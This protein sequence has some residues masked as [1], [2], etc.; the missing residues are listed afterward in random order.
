VVLAW[1][2]SQPSTGLPLKTIRKYVCQRSNPAAVISHLVTM[3]GRISYRSVPLRNLVIVIS[4]LYVILSIV[5]LFQPS[6]LLVVVESGSRKTNDDFLSITNIDALA[7]LPQPTR[8][9]PKTIILHAPGALQRMM[10][11][12][13]QQSQVVRRSELQELPPN[14]HKKLAPGGS[15]A[16]GESPRRDFRL[17]DPNLDKIFFLVHI[18]K[19]AGSSMCQMA[20][21]N[22]L[23][24]ERYSN[25]NVQYDLRCCG[26]QDSVEAQ[27]QF[28]KTSTYDFVAIEKEMYHSMAPEYY[29]YI[30]ILRNSRLRYYSH[31]NHIVKEFQGGSAV[32][33][34]MASTATALRGNDSKDGGTEPGTRPRRGP[35]TFTTWWA[36]QPDNWNTRMICGPKCLEH[37]KY[38]I[39]RP[40][41][42]ET[43]SRLALFEDILFVESL[44]ESYSNFTLK[45][46]W[47]T[48]M[49]MDKINVKQNMQKN[50]TKAS[51]KR[52]DPL[53]S[54]LDDALYEFG[55][56]K[57]AGRLPPNSDQQWGQFP[58]STPIQQQL[59]AYFAMG[60]LQNCTSICC[61]DKCSMY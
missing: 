50:A 42:E 30:V 19:S 17:R 51:L 53:M 2:S 35:G 8:L 18:H 33:S 4:L 21:R 11:I 52:W 60:P 49:S 44:E 26:K 61:A 13:Q 43:L 41:F 20:R 47:S 31:W 59:E 16:R 45:H 40:L 1:L 25:C 6:S 7:N 36:H 12:E 39:P 27:V 58:F 38:Q 37:A 46:S 54:A 32:G 34:G 5:T 28:A 55:Q 14:N 56:L 24:A 3:T 29:H 9:N 15:K 57:Q 10:Q 48:T 22:H 23:R